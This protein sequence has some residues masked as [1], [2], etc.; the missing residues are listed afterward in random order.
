MEGKNKEMEIPTMFQIKKK[1]LKKLGLFLLL[2]LIPSN[3]I[4]T[5]LKTQN[6]HQ[7]PYLLLKKRSQVW[8]N[9]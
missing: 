1:T 4:G 7:N 2:F 9:H 5:N 3:L 8:Q 6:S